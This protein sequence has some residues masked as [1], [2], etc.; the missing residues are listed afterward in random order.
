[1][2]TS[3]GRDCSTIWLKGKPRR[4]VAEKRCEKRN[5]LLPPGWRGPSMLPF[6]RPACP[7]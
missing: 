5:D 3:H 6:G 7:A 4:Q 1:M 2:S